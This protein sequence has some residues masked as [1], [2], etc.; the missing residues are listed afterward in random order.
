MTTYNGE[1]FLAEQ[2]DS[3]LHQDYPHIQ[4]I[5]VDDC[6][7]DKTVKILKK[8]AS[9]GKINFYQNSENLGYVKNFEKAIKLCSGEFVALADQ[10]DLWKTTKI[11]RLIDEI[12]NNVLVHTDAILIDAERNVIADSYSLYA[13]KMVHPNSIS[14]VLLNGS[15]TGCTA[16]VRMSFLK[17]AL[18][19]PQGLY[20]HDKWLA[21]LAYLENGLIYL[22]HQLVEYRQHS[23]NSIGVSR[24]KSPFSQKFK[25]L[26]SHEKSKINHLPFRNALIKEYT[27]V[28]RLLEKKS[29]TEKSIASIEKVKTFYR[30]ILLGKKLTFVITYFFANI[31]SFE[32][33]KPFIQKIYY[34]YLI[35]NSFKY[36]RKLGVEAENELQLVDSKL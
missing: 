23:K 29:L 33:N 31:S 13:N 25:R 3:I 6:S 11:S 35:L 2:I 24:Y 32:K 30:Y 12:G 26:F 36:S 17:S 22:P 28:N 4:V 1:S 34:F 5:V 9:L 14:D 16:L 10:D 21:I 20:V 27:L 15:V 8:Y 19:F 18:P 7:T